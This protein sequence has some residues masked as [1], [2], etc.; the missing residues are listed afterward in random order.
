MIRRILIPLF[1]EKE[2]HWILININLYSLEIQIYDSFVSPDIKYTDINIMINR[3]AARGQIIDQIKKELII[4]K[5]LDKNW[6]KKD[7]KFRLKVVDYP[8]K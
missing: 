4:E 8:S 5:V 7:L 3:I 6:M 2:K 1:L